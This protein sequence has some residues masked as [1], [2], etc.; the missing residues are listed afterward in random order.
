MFPQLL[1]SYI[2]KW[3]FIVNTK[4]KAGGR[5]GEE[6]M[7]ELMLGAKYLAHSIPIATIIY[8]IVLFIRFVC[9][10]PVANSYGKNGVVIY[11]F[12]IYLTCVGFFQPGPETQNIY[13]HCPGYITRSCSYRFSPFRPSF[14]LTKIEAIFLRRRGSYHQSVL[15]F[16]FQEY[17]FIR[18][19]S[20]SVGFGKAV[21]YIAKETAVCY[22]LSLNGKRIVFT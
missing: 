22:S 14:S 4:R 11:L 18:L 3:G 6:Q 15:Q 9:N 1:L 10:K 19:L 2:G 16:Y 12:I 20:H 21:V 8:G 17:C 7:N 5:H 13:M